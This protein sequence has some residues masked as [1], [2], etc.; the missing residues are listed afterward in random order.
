MKKLSFILAGLAFT[1]VLL[2]NSNNQST[3]QA[4][5]SSSSKVPIQ[6]MMAD[7]DTL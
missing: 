3:D 5:V 1:F 7:G 2:G 6:V 4:K